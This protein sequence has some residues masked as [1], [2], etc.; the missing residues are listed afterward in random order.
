MAA[1]AVVPSSH[2]DGVDDCASGAWRDSVSIASEELC[3]QARAVSRARAR[4]QQSV[5][6]WAWRRRRMSESASAC[7][8]ARTCAC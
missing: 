6:A 4:A 5:R 1:A 8:C 3:T 2:C 7:A